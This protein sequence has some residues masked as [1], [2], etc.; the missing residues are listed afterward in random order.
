MSRTILVAVIALAWSVS[1]R[2][3]IT[4]SLDPGSPSGAGPL[5]TWSYSIAV[6]A[7][8]TLSPTA[9]IGCNPATPCPAGSFFTLYDIPGLFAPSAPANWGSTIQLTGITPSLVS[10][11]DSAAVENL[12]FFY[13]GTLA[14]GPLTL[15]GF[16]F[17]STSNQVGTIPYAFSATSMSVTGG[18]NG[19]SGSGFV[20]GPG[21]AP[22]PEPASLALIGAG[23]VGLALRRKRL[24]R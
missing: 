19:T 23:L 14:P 11:G 21:S 10:P 1:A 22:T 18:L 24:Q 2:A 15:S 20:A 13:T 3:D 17:L 8:E 9:N 5:F 7:S 6:D 4:P 16:S 12:T